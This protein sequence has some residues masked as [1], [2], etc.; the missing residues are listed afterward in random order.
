V[1]VFD[2]SHIAWLLKVYDPPIAGIIRRQAHLQRRAKIV[3][4]TDLIRIDFASR[5]PTP[6]PIAIGLEGTVRADQ[7]NTAIDREGFDASNARVCAAHIGAL[8]R[9]PIDVRQIARLNALDELPGNGQRL[10]R[11]I[12]HAG[13]RAGGPWS[14]SLRESTTAS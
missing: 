10:A 8:V 7:R 12:G 4:D 5:D 3:I 13:K 1:N 2:R 6:Q 11:D 14:A 9:Q